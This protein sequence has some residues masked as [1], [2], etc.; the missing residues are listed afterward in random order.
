MWM[1]SRIEKEKAEATKLQIYRE[2]HGKCFVC[3]RPLR[4]TPWQLAHIIPKKKWC[5]ERWGKEVVHHR[6]NLRGTCPGRCNDAVN[7]DPATH[8]LHA[9]ELIK[10]ILEDLNANKSC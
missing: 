8:P 9:E 10:E 7:M 6:L 1:P 4:D 3:F 5:L 2:Q